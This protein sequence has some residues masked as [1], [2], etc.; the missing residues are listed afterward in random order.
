[1]KNIITHKDGKITDIRRI[2]NDTTIENIAVV[3]DIPKF[4]PKEGY[5]GILMYSLDKGIYWDYKEAPIVETNEYGIDNETYNQIIDDYTAN[6]IE[7]V[8]I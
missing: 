6:I 5:N 8:V 4:E 1:M 7:Q 3:G 2:G